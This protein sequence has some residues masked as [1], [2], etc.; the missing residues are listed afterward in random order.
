MREQKLR[1]SR[2]VR[3]KER[4]ILCGIW[5]EE[6]KLESQ[7]RSLQ[8]SLIQD[9]PIDQ[10]PQGPDLLWPLVFDS[11]ESPSPSHFLVIPSPSLRYWRELLPC[12]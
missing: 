6:L 9:H 8:L 5:G 1:A 7:A 12:N 2:G 10:A 11:C 3:V 4:Y